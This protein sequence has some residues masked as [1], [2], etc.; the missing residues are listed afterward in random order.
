MNTLKQNIQ[1]ETSKIINGTRSYM[2]G[3]AN[4][5]QPRQKENNIIK[6]QK[7]NPNPTPNDNIVFF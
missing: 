2:N 6:V 5:L 4:V 3:V 7:N 1:S